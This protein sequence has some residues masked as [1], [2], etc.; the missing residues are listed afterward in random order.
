M[1]HF[2]MR[3]DEYLVKNKLLPSR[4]KAKEWIKSGKVLVNSEKVFKTSRKIMDKDK[5][6]ITERLKYVSRAGYKLEKAIKEFKVHCKGKNC[7]DIGSSTG[8]FVDCLLQKGAK[9]VYA[10]E[11]STGEL[12]E[13]LVNDE[14]VINM[15]GIDVRSDWVIADKA[16]VVSCDCTFL[17]LKDVL[18]K[19]DNKVSND[20]IFVGLI[21]PPFEVKRSQGKM[22]VDS[23]Y[24]EIIE[25]LFDYAKDL[26]W[27]PI[28]YCESPILGKAAGQ[29]EFLMGL[30]K[31]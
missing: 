20:C 3:L 7:L 10:L 30:S 24:L 26:G 2:P 16:E 15:E 29:I 31:K 17:S 21:K 27:E 11:I 4:E 9:R 14:K 5:V 19:L 12:A 25:A 23:G 1:R 13:K 22:K 6:E 8:G 18:P 28:G